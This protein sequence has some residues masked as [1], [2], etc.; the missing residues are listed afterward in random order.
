[1]IH[2]ESSRA[3]QRNSKFC[4]ISFKASVAK[5]DYEIDYTQYGLGLSTVHNCDNWR[6]YFKV[7]CP[8]G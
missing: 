4:K 8:N 2:E 5:G 7:L 3:A 1:M 6:A